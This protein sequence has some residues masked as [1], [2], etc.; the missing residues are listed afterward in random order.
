MVNKTLLSKDYS[1]L[2]QTL[3]DDGNFLFYGDECHHHNTNRFKSHLPKN[4]NFRM[5][6]SAT[7]III[8]MKKNDNLEQFYSSVVAEYSLG[9]AITAKVLTPYEYHPI[10]VELTEEEVEEY[11]ALSLKIAQIYSNK[12]KSRSHSSA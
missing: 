11:N 5:G 8:W 6:L 12:D 1:N 2:L 3:R 4:S 7:P 9:D 10:L